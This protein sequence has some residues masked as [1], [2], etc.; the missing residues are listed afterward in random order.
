[1]FVF[2]KGGMG[3]YAEDNIFFWFYQSFV[4]FCSIAANLDLIVLSLIP[5][6]GLI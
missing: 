6:L 3:T 2:F 4:D 1:M 5:Q